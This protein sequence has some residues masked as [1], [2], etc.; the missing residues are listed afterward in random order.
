MQE[1][2][3]TGVRLSQNVISGKLL[4]W[5]SIGTQPSAP[6]V[7]VPAQCSGGVCCL[8][9]HENVAAMAVECCAAV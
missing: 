1:P 5:Q 7:H 6:S 8:K 2:G 9:G 3:G 4:P